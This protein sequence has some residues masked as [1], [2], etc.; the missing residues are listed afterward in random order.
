[1]NLASCPD[2]SNACSPTAA[3]CPKCGR[4]FQPGDLIVTPNVPDRKKRNLLKLGIVAASVILIL[5]LGLILYQKFT[6][7][8]IA[9]NNGVLTVNGNVTKFPLNVK[10]FESIFGK[11]SRKLTLTNTI[12]V[13][14]DIGVFC[15]GRGASSEITQLSVALN[16]YESEF[17]FEFWPRKSFSGSLSIDGAEINGESKIPLI[18]EK[19]YGEPFRLAPNSQKEWKLEYEDAEISVDANESQYVIEVSFWNKTPKD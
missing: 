11:P 2:C 3:I 8:H 7:P 1:M 6:R 15:Y 12:Y 9:M 16:D 14:D 5:T 19:K 4:N 13:W 18:N 17:P 10:I